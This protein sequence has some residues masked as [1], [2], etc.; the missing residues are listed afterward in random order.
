MLHINVLE[1]EL[2]PIRAER[3]KWEKDIDAV[4][5]VLHEGTNKAV[6]ITNETLA[7]VRAAM[8]INYFDDR[9]IVKEW[10]ELL[11]ASKQ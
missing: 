1:S 4:Y 2:A 3:A 5:D 6:E 10:E 11:I 9:K 7:R 8:R